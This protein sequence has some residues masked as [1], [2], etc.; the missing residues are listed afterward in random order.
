MNDAGCASPDRDTVLKLAGVSPSPSPSPSGDSSPSV[1]PAAGDEPLTAKKPPTCL[2]ESQVLDATARVLRERGYDGATIRAIARQLDCAVGSIYRYFP[3][4]RAL[5]D[6]VCQRRFE[7]VADHAELRSGVRTSVLM[8]ARVASEQPELYRLMFW[9]ASVGKQQLGE[10]VPAVVRRV[11]AGWAESLSDQARAKALWAQLH[12]FIMLGLTPEQ[13]VTML[14][15][16]TAPRQ[17]AATSV[18]RVSEPVAVSVA[19]G[20]ASD[21]SR[22]SAQF[23]DVTLL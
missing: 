12:G 5:L 14:D 23:D 4:K 18:P 2:D 10:A 9:L 20:S 16:P 19:T 22:H 1:A 17:E 11:I 13:A 3:D 21:A 8:Y 6:G 15:L 7:A